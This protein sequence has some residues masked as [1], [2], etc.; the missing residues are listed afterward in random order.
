MRKNSSRGLRPGEK[1]S[2]SKGK[3]RIRLNVEQKKE[4]LATSISIATEELFKNQ[5]Y[6][7]RGNGLPPTRVGPIGLRGTRVCMQLFDRI[8]KRKLERMMVMIRM[9]NRFMDDTMTLLP[10]IRQGWRAEDYGL[11]CKKSWEP[12]DR[13]WLRVFK[14]YE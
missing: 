7:F 14:D 10:P 12:K 11:W 3:D 6:T 5:F 1:G 2:E 13:S 8:W 9:I 4:I